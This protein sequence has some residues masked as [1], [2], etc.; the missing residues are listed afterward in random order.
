MPAK[1]R[2]AIIGVGSI[3]GSHIQGYLDSGRFEI[4]A[5]ADLNAA[6][7][8]EAIERF[9]IAPAQ[10]HDARQDDGR[11]APPMSSRSAPGTRAT[12]PGRFAAATYRPQAILCEKT[13]GRQRR[14][15][16]KAC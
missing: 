2:A 16:R 4:V 15:R 3:A 11:S 9:D 1:L 6:A 10:Y 12:R 13:D 7:M 14:R 5:L 8:A